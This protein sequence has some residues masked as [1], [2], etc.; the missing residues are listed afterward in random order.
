MEFN[1]KRKIFENDEDSMTKGEVLEF[2]INEIKGSKIIGFLDKKSLD[3]VDVEIDEEGEYFT[4]NFESKDYSGRIP[5]K[6]SYYIDELE[7]SLQ[8]ELGVGLAWGF[9]NN[10]NCNRVTF[11]LE[12]DIDPDYATVKT[13][14]SM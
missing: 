5:P 1:L 9:G 4:I 10:G 14:L 7:N 6:I 8:K 3:V 12:T 2:L 11:F 13:I